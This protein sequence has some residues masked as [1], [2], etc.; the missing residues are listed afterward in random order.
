[1]EHF[2]DNHTWACRKLG[3][4]GN[5][6]C[7]F[8]PLQSHPKACTITKRTPQLI[9]S[10]HG[11]LQITDPRAP[12]GFLVSITHQFPWAWESHLWFMFD[13]LA[14]ARHAR[15]PSGTEQNCEQNETVMTPNRWVMFLSHGCSKQSSSTSSASY[16][17]GHVTGVD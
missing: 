6:L 1:M 5:W 15:L 4:P 9:D 3:D 11:G 2:L 14:R 13:K 8:V 16:S 17:E 12:R 7:S 10:L